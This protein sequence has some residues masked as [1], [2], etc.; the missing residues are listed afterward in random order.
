MESLQHTTLQT[1]TFTYNT[2]VDSLT[3]MYDPDIFWTE[4]GN[5]SL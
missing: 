3:N 5:C 1:F 2:D 4:D